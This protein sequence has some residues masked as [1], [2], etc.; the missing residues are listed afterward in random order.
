MKV[1]KLA[2]NLIGSEIV[3][4]GNEVNDL[5][6]KGEKIT[7]LTIG[8]LDSNIYPIPAELKAGIQQA[9]A[10]NLTNYPPAAGILPLRQSVSAD[11]KQRYGL[12]YSEKDILIAGGSRPL[13]Y[14]TF[15]TIVDEND[16][17]IYP[18]PSW[19][20]NHYSY[21]TA[22]QKIEIEA[23]PE[24]NF[25]PTAKELAPHLQGAVL[26]ALCSP[27]N[28]TGTMFSKEQLTEI[29]EL[30]VAENKRRSPEQKPLY[31]MYDQIYALLT[32]GEEH[33]NP[34]SLVPQMKDYTIFI[35]GSSKCFAATGVRVG[36]AFG[37]SEIISKMT[38]LLTHIGAWAPKPEQQATATYLKDT[39]SVDSFVSDFK[40]KIKT[41][42]DTLHQGIQSLKNKGLQVDSIPP[43]G[44]LY[45]TIKLD[46]IGKVTPS[47]E[48]LNSS[49]DLVFYLIKEAGMALV[50]FSAFGNSRQMPWF[51]A[52]AGGCSLQDIKD[53]L[54]RLEK[55][56][57]GL[58]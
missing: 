30:I 55:A 12:E 13:I 51:R 17:V 16:K 41:S 47:G 25:L 40:N 58:K 26:I 15:K 29:C 49:T 14:A 42:L 57:E 43:M 19:N 44:A 35:D 22:A 23:S 48:T 27:L 21:L 4:I 11:L 24:N 36:W 20:N 10:D 37:S 28:P 33:Y 5:K 38:A 7:N 6:A 1:S 2:Q 34:V 31:L 9:Y 39:K 8:D 45:L 46:Y 54:P 3:K 53:V 18:V 52:S 50:P 32:F 56:L